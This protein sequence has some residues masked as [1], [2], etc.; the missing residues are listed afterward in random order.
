MPLA[1]ILPDSTGAGGL[2]VI[3]KILVPA[4]PAFVA[5][6]VSINVPAVIGVPLINP[7]DVLIVK[8]PGKFVTA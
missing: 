2:I 3:V 4:P 6:N 8:P 5:F 7:V 1:V